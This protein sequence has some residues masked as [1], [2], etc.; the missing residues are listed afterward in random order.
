[1]RVPANGATS[2]GFGIY[3]LTRLAWS[4]LGAAVGAGAYLAAGYF[5]LY[6][7]Q[8]LG[9]R[10]ESLF[11]QFFLILPMGLG[12]SGLAAGAGLAR[13]AKRPWLESV[14]FCPGLWICPAWFLSIDDRAI[15]LEMLA[16]LAIGLLVSWCG[17]C[18]GVHP[19]RRIRLPG[20]C[21][22]CGYNLSGNVSGVCP[23]CGT[24]I[25]SAPEGWPR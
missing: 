2:N 10:E 7:C 17:T 14:L 22:K 25:R 1:M 11:I 18:I 15:R 20:H 21:R 8:L 4:A 6:M 24:A 9:L 12:L 19:W 23:E 16:P 13:R 3:L 5:A